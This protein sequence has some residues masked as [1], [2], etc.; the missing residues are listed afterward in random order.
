MSTF[1]KLHVCYTKS[2][3]D[4]LMGNQFIDVMASIQIIGGQFSQPNLSAGHLPFYPP[5]TLANLGNGNNKELVYTLH[6]VSNNQYVNITDPN[7]QWGNPMASTDRLMHIFMDAV[8]GYI[9]SYVCPNTIATNAGTIL[10]LPPNPTVSSWN[11]GPVSVDTSISNVFTGYAGFF[12]QIDQF[13]TSPNDIYNSNTYP[14]FNSWSS[15]PNGLDEGNLLKLIIMSTSEI[16]KLPT[17]LATLLNPIIAN[18]S[19]RSY[20]TCCGNTVYAFVFY[21]RTTVERDMV[22]ST[23]VTTIVTQQ[24]GPAPY[25][26]LVLFDFTKRNSLSQ[27]VSGILIESLLNPY[28]INNVPVPQGYATVPS[29]PPSIIPLEICYLVKPQTIVYYFGIPLQYLGNGQQAV[30]ILMGMNDFLLPS[31]FDPAGIL[32]YC[33]GETLPMF[34]RFLEG[35]PSASLYLHYNTSC[36]P[37]YPF[38]F[39]QQVDDT[40][41]R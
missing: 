14:P 6:S 9:N 26:P 4:K 1:T 5:A 13:A 33:F 41:L 15:L 38:Q 39:W 37:Q 12:G 3:Q 31:Y 34:Q 23:P 40:V 25:I 35:Y 2:F 7:S 20:H 29:G 21:D 28:L 27:L 11:V 30:S 22:D 19:I 24:I 16:P 32:P 18:A 8:I 36:F 17:F 10:P